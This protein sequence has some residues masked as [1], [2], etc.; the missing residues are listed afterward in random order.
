MVS[1]LSRVNAS[2]LV[3]G[4]SGTG[5]ELV[6]RTLHEEGPGRAGPF[7]PVN[8]GAIPESLVES[9]FFGH[10]RGAFTGA[11]EGR[12]GKFE[13][14]DGGTLFL[15]EV[16]D[17]TPMAQGKLLRVL[18]DR[19]I[20]RL[21]GQRPHS[22]DSRVIAATNKDLERQSRKGHFREDLFWRLQVVKIELPPLRQRGK[23]LFLLIDHFVRRFSA[24]VGSAPKSLSPEALR[25]LA[26]YPWPGNVRELKNV[27]HQA[28]ILSDGST[29]GSADLPARVRNGLTDF[30]QVPSDLDELPLAAAVEQVTERVEMG[31]IRARLAKHHGNRTSTAE[32]LGVSRKTLYN[33]MRRYGLTF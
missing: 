2:V 4:E 8:C 23:D 9:E 3:A 6:A 22:A 19:R 27:L 29:I 31:L 26:S 13:Q 20:V 7:V 14:A 11:R 33:K 28:V 21:G 24:E 1:K 5:K 32:S 30:C 25:T 15:D 16:G 18:E 10:E 17:L 12:P